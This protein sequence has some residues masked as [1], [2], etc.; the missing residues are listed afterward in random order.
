VKNSSELKRTST[1]RR[2]AFKTEPKPDKGPKQVKCAN[3][4]KPSG[5][6]NTMQPWCSIDCAHAIA[7]KR[8]AMKKAKDAREERAKTKVQKEALKSRG[9]LLKETQDACNAVVRFRDR[10]EPCFCCGKWEGDIYS[11]AGGQWDAGHYLSR[12]SHPNLRFDLR[13]I[14]R[15]LK[16]CNRPGGT[17]KE[18]MQNGVRARIGEKAL[19]ELEADKTPRHWTH[20]DLREMRDNFR[21]M[22]RQMK[23]EA[24]DA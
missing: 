15:Q 21:K 6:S 14:H 10:N 13:N 4:R 18:A 19:A 23:K 3:C 12:G 16:S 2:T 1:L 22:L 17:T 11:G 7:L 20:D 5:H 8:L 24:N 9:E